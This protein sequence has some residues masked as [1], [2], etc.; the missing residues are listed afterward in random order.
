MTRTLVITAL[1][2]LPAVAS[3]QVKPSVAP[4]Y[5]VVVGPPVLGGRLVSGPPIISGGTA[6][7][8]VQNTGGGSPVI[9]LP[10]GTW[11]GA[12]YPWPVSP[13]YIVPN[14]APARAATTPRITTYPLLTTYPQ[15]AAVGQMRATL[16]IEFPAAAEI[17]VDGKTGDGPPS[18]EWVLTSPVL[19]M[20]ESHTFEVKG[21]WKTGGKTFEASR[22]VTVAA[23]DRNRTI[24]V[25]GT[26]I[27]K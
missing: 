1:L 21:R 4:G 8:P 5:S 12:N 18:T 3:A 22:S 26:E 27:Q 15:L 19:K 9:W 25:S 23:G 14:P 24:I 7:Y 17:W 13:I 11:G 2:A 16:I 20:G 10:S 6:L